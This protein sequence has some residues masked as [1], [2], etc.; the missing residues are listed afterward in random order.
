[1]LNCLWSWT[2]FLFKN[3][4]RIYLKS[5]HCFDVYCKNFKWKHL[6]NKIESYEI[7]GMISPQLCYLQIDNI[8][9]IRKIR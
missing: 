8:V 3:K 9:A 4:I 5:G 6:D 7:S 2:S 1:M